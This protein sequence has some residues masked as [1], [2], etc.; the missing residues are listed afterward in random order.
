MTK[1]FHVPTFVF[2][3]RLLL[4]FAIAISIPAATRAQTTAT[5]GLG[6]SSVEHPGVDAGLRVERALNS[7]VMIES[8]SAFNTA[9]KRDGGFKLGETV[10]LRAGHLIGGADYR[11]RDGG[12]WVKQSVWAVVGFAHSTPDAEWRILARVLVFETQPNHVRQFTYERRDHPGS[13]RFG[14]EGRGGLMVY[15]DIRPDAPTR[16]GGFGSVSLSVRLG[17]LEAR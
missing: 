13:G 15:T 16:Y 2:S 4:M 7:T 1:T 9:Q 10:L 8:T 6:G 17:R 3:N 5:I 14:V 11:Y 12:P